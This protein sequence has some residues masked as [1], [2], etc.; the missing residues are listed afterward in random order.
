MT[1]YTK[2]Q[3]EPSKIKQN[4]Q[5]QTNPHEVARGI[6]PQITETE[7]SEAFQG[8]NATNFVYVYRRCNPVVQ[9]QKDAHPHAFFQDTLDRLS[10]TADPEKSKSCFILILI[11]TFIYTFKTYFPPLPFLLTPFIGIP[12]AFFAASFAASTGTNA[13]GISS[14]ASESTFPGCR[15]ATLG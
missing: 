14:S 3:A 11:R 5:N 6:E 2:D 7:V 9:P 12:T 1:D 15:H 13:A 4:Q 8:H 10:G